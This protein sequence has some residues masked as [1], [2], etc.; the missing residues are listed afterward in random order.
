MTDPMNGL[1][2]FQEALL[3][4]L[5][6]PRPGQFNSS[7]SVLEDN[8]NGELRV[9]H[10]RV[11]EEAVHGTVMYCVVDPVGRIPCFS[12]GYAVSEEQRRQGVGASLLQESI[13]ELRRE[14]FRVGVKDF[15]IE[16]IVGINNDA[17]NG[18]ASKI[19]SHD[20]VRTTDKVS[21]EPAFQYLKRI[22]E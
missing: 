2:S 16:A 10:A 22:K 8:P 3:Q 1:L 13:E 12:V 17:S 15:Y 4:K 20:P 7:L 21:G 11:V 19:L 18:L 14:M 9:T 5:I 6:E